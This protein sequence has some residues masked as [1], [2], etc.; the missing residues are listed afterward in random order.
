MAEII[1]SQVLV[2]KSPAFTD[3]GK[4]PVQFTGYGK[5]ISPELVIE[6]LPENTKYL[7]VAFCDEDM[8]VSKEYC[9]W[10]CWN[11]PAVNIIP[12]KIPFGAIIEEPFS[13]VQGVGY[14]KHRYR[15]PKPPFH[16]MHNYHFTVYA[17]DEKLDL[18]PSAKFKDV[19]KAMEGH[20]LQQ[21]QI[22]CWYQKN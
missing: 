13:A 15:G 1:L 16:A 9:H 4:L 5:D 19:K 12:Q 18:Q 17:L 14:G 20:I 7:A 22:R 10:I 21:G 11:I 2:I 6:N 8:P 3:G